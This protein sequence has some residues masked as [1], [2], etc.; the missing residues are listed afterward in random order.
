MIFNETL[1]E[2]EMYVEQYRIDMDKNEPD[3]VRMA[4]VCLPAMNYVNKDL[5]FTK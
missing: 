1:G 2:F 5:R 4:R 3:N